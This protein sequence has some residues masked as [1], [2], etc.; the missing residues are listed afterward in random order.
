MP[1]VFFKKI[2]IKFYKFLNLTRPIFAKLV[3]PDQTIFVDICENQPIFINKWV[4]Y[5]FTFFSLVFD[6]DTRQGDPVGHLLP[7]VS[8]SS[9]ILLWIF[10]IE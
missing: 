1:L 9:S 5:Y 6:I 2:V 8:P 4:N 7:H 3:K 10:L